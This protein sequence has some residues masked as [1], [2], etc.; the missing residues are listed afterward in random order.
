MKTIIIFPK[1]S[2]QEVYNSKLIRVPLGVLSI[3]HQAELAGIEVTILDERRIK[4]IQQEIQK[5][6]KI[7]E[8][9]CIGFSVMTGNQ[10]H[11]AQ[12]LS[13]FIKKNYDI[14]IIWGGVHPTLEP[15]ST[16]SNELIDYVVIGEGEYIFPK[17]VQAINK[18]G[19]KE[20][21]NGIAFKKENGEIVRTF[22]PALPDMNK[23]AGIKYE[24][25]PLQEYSETSGFFNFKTNIILPVEASRGCPFK[26]T[27]CTEPVMERSW[28]YM[29]AQILINELHRIKKSYGIEAIAFTD[30]LFFVKHSH[31]EE[32]IDAMI[33]TK[34]NI[35][36]YANIRAEYVVKYGVDFFSKVS[37]SG[38]R[39]LTMGA[40]GGTDDALKRVRKGRIT[41][42]SLTESNLIL[43][44]V[45]IAPHYSS[46]IGYPNEHPTEL[47]STI[48]LAFQLLSDNPL[49]RVS[50]NKLIPTPKSKILTECVKSGYVEPDTL[51]KWAEVFY[52]DASSWLMLETK[53]LLTR[54]SPLCELIGMVH[55][56]SEIHD[57]LFLFINSIITNEK[58]IDSL[59]SSLS[60][61]D[62]LSQLM[63]FSKDHFERY[64]MFGAEYSWKYR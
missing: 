56:G 28:R 5:T 2:N 39:S 52:T 61:S 35:E 17:L 12:E 47:L 34:L 38:C 48:K 24:Q 49:C 20:I 64:P 45:G 42:S 15:T 23:L 26:C 9:V 21:I 40:E 30:D 62:H 8:P 57:E 33:K 22:E 18:G 44:Q 6:I 19:S 36:W 7:E 60:T 10:I 50:L 46:I 29:D 41:V 51:I 3:A 1:I 43:R 63:N 55:T 4:N 58:S 59:F 37:Q 16:L 32:I 54:L 13:K 27:F 53:E 31:S 11:F 14:P 25:L